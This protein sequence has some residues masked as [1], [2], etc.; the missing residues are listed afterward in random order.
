M[1]KYVKSIIVCIRS[2]WRWNK[3]AY[4]SPIVS[5]KTRQRCFT[6]VSVKCI[7]YKV[8]SLY[9]RFRLG[10]DCIQLAAIAGIQKWT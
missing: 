4:K 9:N 7:A 6:K 1:S 10:P 3:R 2:K 5:L 8:N